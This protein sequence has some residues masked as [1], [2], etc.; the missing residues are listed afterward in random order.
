MSNSIKVYTSVLISIP[1]AQPLK[2]LSRRFHILNRN[3]RPNDRMNHSILRWFPPSR[4]FTTEVMG[5]E[6]SMTPS[7]MH[8]QTQ[9]HI[10]VL[11]DEAIELIKPVTLVDTLKPPYLFIDATFGA[12]GYTKRLLGT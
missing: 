5:A 2:L 7:H 1:K 8:K 12:G 11:L 6:V 3:H 4:M 10:P 9:A